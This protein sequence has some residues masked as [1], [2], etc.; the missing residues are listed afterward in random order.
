M[1]TIMDQ[2]NATIYCEMERKLAR[3]SEKYGIPLKELLELLDNDDKNVV[4]ILKQNDSNKIY[5]PK[6]RI[7]S[8]I[9][10][11][12]CDEEELIEENYDY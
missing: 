11:D 9:E 2:I 4:T 8:V 12:I 3:I 6:K 1:T 5:P 7:E 10:V